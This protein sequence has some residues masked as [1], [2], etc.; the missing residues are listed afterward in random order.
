MD[1]PSETIEALDDL[2]LG[3]AERLQEIGG[4]SDGYCIIYRPRGMHTNG[5]CR[6]NTEKYK[7]T[8]VVFAYQSFVK[9]VR[10]LLEKKP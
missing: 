10:H 8:K 2:E 5:G 1:S 3:L 4:C 6:C 7:M 9:D